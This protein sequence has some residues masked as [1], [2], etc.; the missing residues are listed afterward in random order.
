K[1]RSSLRFGSPFEAVGHDKQRRIRR[2]AMTW[3]AVHR[4]RAHHLRFDVVAV[5]GGR[6]EVLEAA[7]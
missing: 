7:F 5:T 3:L 1:T 6:I 2:L 4:A